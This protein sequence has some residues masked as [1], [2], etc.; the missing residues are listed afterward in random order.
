[1]R[2]GVLVK[3]LWV[4]CDGSRESVRSLAAAGSS[5]C[6]G[7]PVKAPEACATTVIWRRPWRFGATALR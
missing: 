3:A 2:G 4:G 6:D 7:T 5:G 1:V